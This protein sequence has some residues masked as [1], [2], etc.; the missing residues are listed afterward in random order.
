ME[1][2]ETGSLLLGQTLQETANEGCTVLDMSRFKSC[3]YLVRI[4]GENGVM[5]QKVT[6]R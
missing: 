3:M 2:S 1:V 5:M 4:E 6:I